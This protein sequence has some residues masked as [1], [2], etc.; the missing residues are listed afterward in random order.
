MRLLKFIFSK[1]FLYQLILAAIVSVLIIFALL[2]WLD[3]TT[4]QGQEITV[5]DL[6]KLDLDIV[7]KKL[8]EMNLRFEIMDSASFNPDYPPKSVLDQIPQEGSKVKENRKIYLTLN[9]SGYPDVEIPENLNR[10]SL[11]QVQPALEAIG[12]KIGEIE[13]KPD[14]AKDVVLFILHDKDTLKP[15]DKL[16]KTSTIDLI[17][18]DGK[19][20]YGEKA[21]DDTKEIEDV[22]NTINE[23]LEDEVEAESR[24]NSSEE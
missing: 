9:P 3:Y 11:R 1:T 4:D 17:I 13:E 16:E 14:I 24:I 7:E 8:D 22:L 23:N 20:T 21:S 12:F 5:P 6:S 15:G 10:R 2:K 18:G 19:L